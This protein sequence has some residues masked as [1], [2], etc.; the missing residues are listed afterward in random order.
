[1][2]KSTAA[3]DLTRCCCLLL[4]NQFPV[5]SW[6]C[7]GKTH[8]SRWHI[9]YVR[10]KLQQTSSS[11]LEVQDTPCGI[12]V[13]WICSHFH[14]QF[15]QAVTAGFCGQGGGQST[16]LGFPIEEQLWL[17][18]ER[19]TTNSHLIGNKILLTKHYLSLVKKQ[20]PPQVSHSA[21]RSIPSAASL[22]FYAHVYHCH[23]PSIHQMPSDLTSFAL[24]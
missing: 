11:E 17:K 2:R 10:K 3:K 20:D 6:L 24:K 9:P 8:S 21:S 13:P 5:Q 14:E 23:S 7:S 4:S 1:M 22:F 18:Q 12:W 15:T 16:L 19:T